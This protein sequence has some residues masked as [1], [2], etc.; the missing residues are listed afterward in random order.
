MMQNPTIEQKLKE[1]TKE[2][3]ELYEFV[4]QIFE[5]EVAGK[6]FSKFYENEIKKIVQQRKEAEA[7]GLKNRDQKLQAIQRPKTLLFER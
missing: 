6:Q 2:N 3:P 4:S 5:L 7:C 1:K